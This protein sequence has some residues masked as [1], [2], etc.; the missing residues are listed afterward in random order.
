MKNYF[1]G[2]LHGLNRTGMAL[3]AVSTLLLLVLVTAHIV[4]RI[5]G[6]P[7]FLM[8]EY[9]SFLMAF[10]V[11]LPLGFITWSAA[12]LSAD[13]LVD[14]MSTRLKRLIRR[15]FVPAGMACFSVLLILIAAHRTHAS[16]VGNLRSTGPLSTPLVVPQLGMML[17]LILLGLTTLYLVLRGPIESPDVSEKETEHHGDRKSP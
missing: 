10:I 15:Y 13:F 6:V 9:A 16:W 4:A 14:L 17:G 11:L 12:H 7:F 3:G 2:L 8:F 5:I 1:E